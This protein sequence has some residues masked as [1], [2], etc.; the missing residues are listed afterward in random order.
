MNITDNRQTDRQRS[1]FYAP[2]VV[3]VAII[4]F[5]DDVM[6]QQTNDVATH[7]V[8]MTTSNSH[9][10]WPAGGYEGAEFG[11]NCVRSSVT[12]GAELNHFATC[13]LYTSPSPRDS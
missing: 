2:P 8:D 9:A 13:L 5:S 3:G 1:I 11:R 7:V 6:F 12:A 10:P 4:E